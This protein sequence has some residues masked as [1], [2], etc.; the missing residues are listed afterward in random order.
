MYIMKIMDKQKKICNT[1]TLTSYIEMI[2]DF[3][4]TCF[5]NSLV[6][7]FGHFSILIGNILY[8][9]QGIACAAIAENFLFKK[10]ISLIL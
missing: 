6:T 4:N 8:K 10:Y 7:S 1:S 2:K 5:L 3:S 9:L